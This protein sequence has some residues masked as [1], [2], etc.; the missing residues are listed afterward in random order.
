MR[1][2]MKVH[3]A[4]KLPVE[5]ETVQFLGQ[6]NGLSCVQWMRDNGA[7]V[8]HDDENIFIHT[9]EGIMHVSPGDWIIKGVESEFYPCKPE[10]FVKTY[11]LEK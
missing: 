4:R 6:T 11:E 9:L 7:T 3:K 1:E 5:I 2:E 8:D 10:I